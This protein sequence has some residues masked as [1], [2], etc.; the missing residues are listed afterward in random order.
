MGKDLSIKIWG[1][2]IEANIDDYFS[3]NFKPNLVKTSKISEMGHEEEISV[4]R[5]SPNQKLIATGG[6][7]KIIKVLNIF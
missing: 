4:V 3:E 1:Y 2:E 6:Y 7:D 5:Y